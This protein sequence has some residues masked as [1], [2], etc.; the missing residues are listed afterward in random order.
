MQHLHV[1]KVL[2]AEGLVKLWVEVLP[3]HLCLVLWLL[4]REEVDLDEGVRQPCR[5]VRG[6]EVLALYHLHVRMRG[7]RR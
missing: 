6:R 2:E 4:V 1:R 5:P 3:V 7:G